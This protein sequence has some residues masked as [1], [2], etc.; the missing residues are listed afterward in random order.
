MNVE[1]IMN[2][3]NGTRPSN[4][5]EVSVEQLDEFINRCM[6]EKDETLLTLG[7]ALHTRVTRAQMISI[8]EAQILPIVLQRIQQRLNKGEV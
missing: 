4:H 1:D 8:L 3:M 2:H 5:S 7:Q 6:T